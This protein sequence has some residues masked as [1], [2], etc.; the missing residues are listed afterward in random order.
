MKDEWFV[1]CYDSA[2]NAGLA[3][4]DK[5]SGELLFLIQYTGECTH[6]AGQRLEEKN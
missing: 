6:F 1:A 5:I 4:S 2:V 3:V